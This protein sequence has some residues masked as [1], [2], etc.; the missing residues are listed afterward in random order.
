[1]SL[2]KKV[3]TLPDEVGAELDA[4]QVV[5]LAALLVEHHLL[6]LSPILAWSIHDDSMV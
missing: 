6:Q 4:G 2:Q 3:P 5:R 1:M